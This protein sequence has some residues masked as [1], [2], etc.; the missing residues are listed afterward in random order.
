MI[1]F[2]ALNNWGKSFK[3][4]D[5]WQPTVPKDTQVMLWIVELPWPGYTDHN[6]RVYSRSHGQCN[7][8]SDR[9]PI[10]ATHWAPMLTPPSGEV[11][12]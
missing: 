7:V 1:D 2:A 3:G 9:H 8:R 11:K 5:M 10:K 12:P 4:R 6:G